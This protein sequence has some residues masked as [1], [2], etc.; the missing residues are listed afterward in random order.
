MAW[1]MA[2]VRH[3]SYVMADSKMAQGKMVYCNVSDGM[4]EGRMA[5][6]KMVNGKVSDGK[7]VLGMIPIL[8][9]DRYFCIHPTE[10]MTV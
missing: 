7:L 1:Q 4:A 9:T 6:G 10:H 8:L 2:K 5:Q 3:M